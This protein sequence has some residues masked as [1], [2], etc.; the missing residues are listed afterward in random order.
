MIKRLVY[1]LRILSLFP[2][3]IMGVGAYAQ[4]VCEPVSRTV[5]EP[6][7]LE[8]RPEIATDGAGN[9]Y[10]VFSGGEIIRFAKSNDSGKS[11][12]AP[13]DLALTDVEIFPMAAIAA[14]PRSAYD[15][16]AGVYVIFREL[17]PP[18]FFY[19]LKFMAS[20]DSGESWSEPIVIPDT[21]R[22][23][24]PVIAVWRDDSVDRIAIAFLGIGGIKVS[25][26]ADGGIT[27]NTRVIENSVDSVVS[28]P[29]IAFSAGIVHLVYPKP[30]LA[31]RILQTNYTRSTDYGASFDPPRVISS[32]TRGNAQSAFIAA[33]GN[34][35]I[36]SWADQR[37]NIGG[38][39]FEGE[40][41]I[42]TSEDGGVSFNADQRFT[43][44]VGTPACAVCGCVRSTRVA[45]HENGL[46]Y[47]S[48][49][50]ERFSNPGPPRCL[51]VRILGRA[52]TDFGATFSKEQDLSE[53]TFITWLGQVAT[54]GSRV[55]HSWAQR[56][57]DGS[58]CR[59]S[60][61]YFIVA[62][63]LACK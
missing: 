62:N 4:I 44:T 61:A 45:M 3:L 56:D 53:N 27:W 12:A 14:T 39:C 60:S 18:P 31:S 9:V 24:D 32:N 34:Q 47:V 58:V 63:A 46:T 30:D 36:V 15:P 17:A 26:S 11:Y 40:A 2:L 38:F 13:I 10:S 50:D 41:Y 42:A 51:N 35:L 28:Y 5:L 48:W 19:R 8:Y 22:V 6:D 49:E 54:D 37:H 21:E 52:S 25:E 16:P 1:A 59:P 55:F 7:L 29:K 33:A 20:M 43:Y 57:G 23:F